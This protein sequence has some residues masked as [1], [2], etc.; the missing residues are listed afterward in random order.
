MVVGDEQPTSRWSWGRRLWLAIEPTAALSADELADYE[1]RR[2]TRLH[3]I[4]RVGLPLGV[5]GHLSAA[6][7]FTRVERVSFAQTQWLET[8]LRLHAI[9]ALFDVCVVLALNV[10]T[11]RLRASR[12]RTAMFEAIL[13]FYPLFG[14]LLAGNAQR[15]HGS[16]GAF[17][18]CVMASATASI[19]ARSSMFVHAAGA[20]ILSLAIIV[21]QHDPA[22]RAAALTTV[23]ATALLGFGWSRISVHN[24]VNEVRSH[25][26]ELLARKS[27]EDRVDGQVREIFTY[28]DEIARLNRHLDA[29]VQ[30]RSKELSLALAR[31]AEGASGRRTITAG[32]IV[33]SRFVVDAP[34][35]TT[36]SVWLAD[37]RVSDSRVVLRVAQA[38]SAVELDAFNKMLAEIQTLTSVH[39]AAFV[40]TV[41]I[42][43]TEDGFLVQALEYVPGLSVEKW[44]RTNGALPPP[45][46]ARIGALVAG[47]LS[48]GH[49]RGMLHRSITP[50][51]VLLSA[52]SPGARLLGFGSV[53]GVLR[54]TAANTVL[55]GVDPEY[56]APDYLRDESSEQITDGRA[57]VYSLGLLLYFALAARSP[58]A[59]T[60]GA[61]WLKAHASEAPTPLG[62]V[63]KNVPTELSALVMRCLAK[64]TAARPTAEQLA[65]ALD[66]FANAQGAISVDAF[67][68]GN[69][70]DERGRRESTR[71]TLTR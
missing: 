64:D 16:Y 9:A 45:M 51:H 47:A 67:V 23:I 42:D 26:A 34:L 30:Q 62:S 63:I 4:L 60:T 43:L 48:E 59:P 49:A 17:V 13:R 31:L 3:R 8:M 65:E 55:S 69:E 71:R 28:V 32:T 66:R 70:I 29:Q 33:A 56:V 57:D 27:L 68:R 18:V 22:L 58:Y 6:A 36:G 52:F 39:H 5:L 37:D 38:S 24:L 61:G 50:A 7:F 10:S 35:N 53:R 2:V 44:V 21:M 14:A 41:H 40:R 11:K 46:V 25:W 15:T 1:Q 12:F 20:T 19:D 54:G